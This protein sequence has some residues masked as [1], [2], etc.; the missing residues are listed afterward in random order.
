MH[1]RANIVLTSVARLRAVHI[2][3]L[4]SLAMGASLK[5]W[6]AAVRRR[7][8]AC[9]TRTWTSLGRRRWF[10]TTPSARTDACAAEGR[11][12]A[13]L[14]AARG[15]ELLGLPVGVQARNG[16]VCA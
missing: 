2:F 16:H 13:T 8:N 3:A 11:G 10:G 5:G 9:S 6:V 14:L 1:F 7:G 15:E 4:F 12:T